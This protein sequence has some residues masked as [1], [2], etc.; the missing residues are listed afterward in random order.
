MSHVWTIAAK[1]LRS[2]FTQAVALI[3]LATFLGMVLFSFFWMDKFFA[4]NIAD[5]R[6]MFAMF[7]L[8]LIF[9]IAALTMRLWSDEQHLGTLEIL[10]TM[11]VPIQRLVMGK[12]LAGIILVAI[13]LVMTL[14]IPIT[15]S[16]MGDLDWGPVIGG[17]VGAL[18]LASAYLAVGMCISSLTEH[19]IVALIF[20]GLACLLLYLPGTEAVTGL[21]GH[22]GAELMRSLAT[23]SR[24]DSIARGVLDVRDI[25]YYLGIIVLF[26][27]INTAILH[28]KRWSRSPRTFRQRSNVKLAV[29]L[30]LA[31]V[32]AANLWLAPVV[33]A[34]ADL[35]ENGEYSLSAPT[36]K[37]LAGLD[38]PLVLR[39]YISDRTHP[40]VQPLAPQIRDLL[41]EY[42]IAGGDKVR[43]EFLDPL[44]DE[45]LEKEAKE[46]FGI[47]TILF[48]FEERNEEAWVNSYFS[49]LVKY[50]DQY[51][52]LNINDLIEV[53]R[54]DI[55]DIKIGLRNLEYD[56]TRTIKKVVYG[57]QS[58]DM[59]F[60]A[61]PGDITLT[62]YIT[63]DTLPPNYKEVPERIERIVKDLGE[64]S[65][66]KLTYKTENPDSK[67]KRTRLYRDY[68]FQ[69]FAT[70]LFAENYY[71]LYLVL[72]VGGTL[73]SVVPAQEMAEADIRQALAEA[74]RRHAPG[75]LKTV[76]IWAPQGFTM[77]ANPQ[78]GGQ[79]Q[80]IPPPQN[81]N[82]V[83][84][85]LAERYKL[86]DVDLDSGRVA[87]DVDVLLVA[88]PDKLGDQAQY[89]I[90]QFLMRGGTTI[91]LA[92]RYRLRLDRDL[93]L[94]EVDT[95]LDALLATYGVDVPAKLVLDEQAETFAIPEGNSNRVRQ[96]SYPF[97]VHVK[98]SGMAKSH[99]AATGLSAVIMQYASPI[100]AAAAADESDEKSAA[101]ADE[102]GGDNL[103]VDR[104][105]L[106]ESSKDA[107]LSA[108]T[109][110][111]PDFDKHPTRGFPG[112][113]A[114][115]ASDPD[116][117]K[118]ASETADDAADE[119]P[120]PYPLAV[121]L[122]GTFPSHFR[123]RG[124]PAKSG[125]EGAPA[126]ARTADRTIKRSPPDTRLVVVGS[127]AFVS[128]EG[129]QLAQLAG[130][131]QSRNNPV[132]IENLIDWA[133][134]DVD[135]LN[136]RSRGAYTRTLEIASDEHGKWEW[137]NY[138]MVIIALLGV[139]G[140]NLLR[141]RTLIPIELS[142]RTSEAK[143]A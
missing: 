78:Y 53:E 35:T 7:P 122:T 93:S 88:G 24:F 128:D 77:P 47:E 121:A 126:A 23:G 117:G 98:K 3:F 72:D 89:A 83:K 129:V 109:T 79:P 61:I 12:F 85:S 51:E 6:P 125:A 139:A 31:N 25:A 74:L 136:I 119:T 32:V 43:V 127:S 45:E 50:G 63:P 16:M 33:S 2:Y 67:E 118:S 75:Y 108:T 115:T 116:D 44:G 18:L 99:V 57:F 60:A 58:M 135:L 56:L 20:T 90:D 84:Q 140:V 95:G 113:A 34:R 37:I 71:Y 38:E 5:V 19:Q 131:R 27:V 49:I 30:C 68:G 101:D 13:A 114:D 124:A 14:G 86:A 54:R 69:P 138:G 26:L 59:V 82:R 4:R 29:A 1:E 65:G 111:L 17:Y 73:T 22:E 76:G 107:W 96:I 102:T 137:I 66:G 52:V 106:L 46:S 87:D 11:P 80:R 105:V 120:A 48:K 42:D 41:I 141:R 40:L 103:D 134:A 133:V 110:I 100:L 28:A 21:F 8:L 70:S 104:E 91:M 39:A 143:G 10:L 55:D 9:L 130:T 62:A 64:Q 92:G 81:F 142:K 132:L 15:V 97:F 94:N 36:R 123:K 112:P